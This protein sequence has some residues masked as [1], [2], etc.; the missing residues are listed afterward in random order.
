MMSPAPDPLPGVPREAFAPGGILALIMAACF[1]VN[2][3]PI[4]WGV[5]ALALEQGRWFTLVSHMFAHANFIHLAFNA[6][7]AFFLGGPIFVRMGSAPISWIRFGLLFFACGFAG[8]FAYV[9][10][11][12][13]SVV[14][15]I[16]ASGA[17]FG[18]IG[19][20]ARLPTQLMGG[21]AAIANDNGVRPLTADLLGRNLFLIAILTLPGLIAP[22]FMAIAWEAHLGGF[23]VGLFLGPLF[24]PKQ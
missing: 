13:A 5:S 6:L 1:I 24:L 4:G 9:L 23:I 18:F 21:S 8:A 22:G 19:I 10:L 15:A 7:I 20:A 3:D 12:P 17:V 14:P 16:G 2:N 11:N